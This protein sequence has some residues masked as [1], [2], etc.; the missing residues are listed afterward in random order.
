MKPWHASAGG[1]N[2]PRKETILKSV[3]IASL[4]SLAITF[5]GYIGVV[6]MTADKGDDKKEE[7]VE[8]T[9]QELAA[10]EF[11]LQGI[12]EQKAEMLS[13]QGSIAAVQ[14]DVKIA[15][16]VLLA[17]QKKLEALHSSLKDEKASI[18]QQ[19]E[20]SL[21]KLAKLYESMKPAEAAKIASQLQ[22]DLVVEIIPRMKERSAAKLLAA[23]D[24]KTA[25][26]IT[27]LISRRK[28]QT[29]DTE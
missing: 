5:G 27:R 28:K 4:L 29:K 17:E 18:K 14:A 8:L 25:A 21:N 2:T 9:K 24:S 10:A 15:R 19:N 20:E 7:P 23:M 13:M 3:I 1:E 16:N 22:N 12:N 26:E 11:Q 6:K